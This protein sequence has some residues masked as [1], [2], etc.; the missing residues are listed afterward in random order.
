M[1]VCDVPVRAIY[2]ANWRSGIRLSTVIYPMSF[3]LA[4]SWLRRLVA[5]RTAPA[6]VPAATAARAAAA[7]KECASAS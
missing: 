6:V 4:R 2:G 7:D 5:K 1:R 3:V